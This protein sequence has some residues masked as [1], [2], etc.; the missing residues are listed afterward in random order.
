M[1]VVALLAQLRERGLDVKLVGGKLVS[2]APKGTLTPELAALLRE[3]RD[4]IVAFLEEGLADFSDSVSIPPIQPVPRQ[5]LMPLSFSQERV[6]YLN[7]VDGHP[8][9]YN[10]PFAAR[11]VGHLDLEVLQRS[12]DTLE[13]RHEALRTTIVIHEGQPFQRI[14]PPRGL[15]LAVIDLRPGPGANGTL[16]PMDALTKVAVRPFDLTVGPLLRT[17]LIRVTET[18]QFLSVVAHHVI[19]DGVSNQIFLRELVLL[20]EA[21]CAGRSSPLKPLPIQFV[22]YAVWQ[23]GWLQGAA[24]EHQL[25]YWKDYLGGELPV[26]EMPGDYPRPA[27]R[28]ADGSKEALHLPRELVQQLTATAA[29]EG[30]TLFI[31]LLTLYKTLLHRHS[32]AIDI[33]VGTPVANRSRVEI[34]GI[35]GFVASTLV[36]RTQLGGN[37]TFRELLRRVR[38]GCI[39]AFRHQDMPFQK[40]VEFLN[41]P[42]DL[43]R[44][45]VFQT[46]FSLHEVSSLP[47]RM[48]EV[49]IEPVIAGN[50]VS[51]MDLCLFL[52]ER[53]GEVFG[54]LEYDT[55]I[56][57]RETILRLLRHYTGLAAHVAADPDRR[58]ADLHVLTDEERA[59]FAAWNDTARAYPEPPIHALVAAQARATPERVAVR[60]CDG[61]LTYGAL[62]AAA[63]R[64]AGVLRSQGVATGDLVGI[65]L[66]RTSDLVPCVLGVL[67][68][69]AAYV[70]MDPEYPQT[71]LAFMAADARL[72]AVMTRQSFVDRL[73]V[74]L[75]VVCVD[76]SPVERQETTGLE[77]VPAQDPELRAY[78]IFTSGSTGR[79]KGVEVRHRNVANFLAAMRERPGI[80]AG[81]VLVAVTTLSFDISVLELFLPLTVGAEVILAD[82]KTAT[83]GAA[84][85]ELIERSGATMLQAT[86]A[87]WRLLLDSGWKGRPGLKALCGGE[88]LP[89]D[90]A[91]CL[92]PI[93]GELWNMYGPTETTVW[94]TCARVESVDRGI[95]IGRPIANTKVWVLDEHM[96]TCPIGVRGE[97]FIGGDGIALGYLDRPDLTSERFVADPFDAT[98]GARL[99]RTGDRGRWRDG[100][101]LEHLGRNDHQVKIR[102]YRIEL[103]EIEANLVALAG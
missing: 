63:R 84:L 18:D 6:W 64:W 102:G 79:P 40:I 93:V 100:G 60:S 92:L 21:G 32:G 81:D 101:W 16:A 73:P 22:D 76:D 58:V 103:G 86:P 26:L 44:T 43:S 8:A 62:D 35:F 47:E 37:P 55:A 14:H 15:A 42:R 56:F 34:E 45:P 33:I 36:L 13:A 82:S 5:D 65:C 46:F 98:P 11:L 23:R 66:D 72:K 51:R 85:A 87:T 19:A 3:R 1:S 20:Y 9:V 29:R 7:Q 68:C 39:G 2:R 67:H 70:P 53:N 4:D 57:A 69:G 30:A 49:T 91:R 41:P 24:L 90:L 38:E 31:V 48:G 78:V 71:R 54:A 12:L 10:M 89:P 27:V 59:A 80:R 88:P 77:L 99:Y 50:D 83:N 97:I 61:D 96:R 25:A 74:G 94:S 95:G 28:T 17:T 52:R 75:A